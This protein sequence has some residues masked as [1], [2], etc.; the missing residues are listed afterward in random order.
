MGL[1]A[2]WREQKERDNEFEN[3]L[4]LPNLRN[5]EEKKTRKK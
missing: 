4:I 3:K 5:R 1:T 2:E